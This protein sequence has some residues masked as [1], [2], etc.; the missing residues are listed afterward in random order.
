MVLIYFTY[1]A[2]VPYA[3]A[4]S[5]FMDRFILYASSAGRT[6]GAEIKILKAER[7]ESA[8]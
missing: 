6:P 5:L 7:M 3:I 8:S 2:V 1:Y 4:A